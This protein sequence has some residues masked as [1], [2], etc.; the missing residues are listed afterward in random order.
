MYECKLTSKRS[1]KGCQFVYF[2]VAKINGNKLAAQKSKNNI[3]EML[4]TTSGDVRMTI[5]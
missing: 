5:K 1:I 4:A 3:Q 2:M